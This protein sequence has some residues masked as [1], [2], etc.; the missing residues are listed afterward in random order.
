MYIL[1]KTFNLAWCAWDPPELVALHP[2]LPPSSAVLIVILKVDTI[3]PS[4]PPFNVSALVFTLYLQ[5]KFS[6][7]S[8]FFEYLRFK[9]T[10]TFFSYFSGAEGNGLSSKVHRIRGEGMPVAAHLNAIVCPI[11]V[12]ASL[13]VDTS[14]GGLSKTQYSMWWKEF[15]L[16]KN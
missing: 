7:K 9:Y 14:L 15:M 16:K 2:Y 4:S 8:H 3:V 10:T 12:I 5:I 13:N 6:L 1:P 11:L